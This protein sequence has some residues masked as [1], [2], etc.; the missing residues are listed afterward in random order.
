M[1]DDQFSMFWNAYPK[2]VGKK[3]CAKA[4]AK[5]N[6]TAN[7]FEQIMKSL[8]WQKASDQWTREGGRFIPNPLTWLNQGR[9]ENEPMETRTIP[10]PTTSGAMAAL[11]RMYAAEGGG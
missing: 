10:M 3:A 9:W 11:Q 8:A 6:L 2:K 7:L 5:L 4:W 1:I